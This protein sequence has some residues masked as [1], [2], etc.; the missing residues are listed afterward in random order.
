[1]QSRLGLGEQ[2]WLRDGAH[3]A[4]SRSQ[5]QLGDLP[6]SCAANPASLM[7]FTGQFNGR[8]DEVVRLGQWTVLGRCMRRGARVGALLLLP[9][10]EAVTEVGTNK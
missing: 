2:L 5:M 8:D 3:I 6:L 9:P 7:A 10:H 4:L 1:M